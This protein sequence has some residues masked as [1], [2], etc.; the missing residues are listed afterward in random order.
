M[1]TY[2]RRAR[3][4]AP[5]DAVWEFH[6]KVEGLTEITPEWMNLRVEAV[7]RPPGA[8]GTDLLVEGTRLRLSARPFGVGPRQRWTSRIREREA[9]DGTAHFRDDMVDGPFRTWVHA[10]R[11][12]A[13]GDATVIDD[14]VEYE[15]PVGPL[16][17]VVNPLAVVGFEPMFRFRHRK[18]RELLEGGRAAEAA[19]AGGRR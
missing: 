19:D 2:R 7:R 9:G 1:A 15:F 18:T 6:S 12:F 8:E 16:G 11:F 5:F 4:D 3:I 17:G 14:R 10:H 13:D